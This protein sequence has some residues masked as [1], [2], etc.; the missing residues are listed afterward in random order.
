TTNYKLKGFPYI[1]KFLS[2]EDLS[3]KAKARLL[4]LANDDFESA[5]RWGDDNP[6]VMAIYWSE[7][8][9]Y[10]L[11]Q[12]LEQVIEIGSSLLQAKRPSATIKLMLV[13]SHVRR[14]SIGESFVAILVQ[15]LEMLL[16]HQ[17]QGTHHELN[18]YDLQ[19][20]FDHL[21]SNRELV[22]VNKLI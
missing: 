5:W 19:S 20:A 21:E 6:N 15:A 17:H 7:F 10:G 14:R 1:Q 12:N 2:M 8:S 3:D 11:G 4:L 9:V 22:E 18:S 16:K 13:Y